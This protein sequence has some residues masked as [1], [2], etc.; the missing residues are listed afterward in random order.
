M[1][2]AKSNGR[3][4]STPQLTIL[5]P[6]RNEKDNLELL[7]PRLDFVLEGIGVSSETIVVDGDSTDG[8]LEMAKRHCALAFPQQGAGYG[9]ALKQGF[10]A[11][12]GEYIV[13]LDADLSHD[14]KFIQRLWENREGVDVVVASRYCEGG[15]A[16]APFFRRFLS[17]V[18]N[19]F[20]SAGFGVPVTDVSSGFRL[21][22]GDVVKAVEFASMRERVR[23]RLTVFTGCVDQYFGYR[24]GRLPYRSIRFEHEHLAG[25]ERFQPV[26]AA[27]V[28]YPNEHAYTRITEFKHITG[29][30]HPGTSI[31]REFPTD[32]GEPYY[33][34]PRP[35]NQ[36]LYRRYQELAASEPK[37]VFLGRLAQYRYYNMDQAAAAALKAAAEIV[38]G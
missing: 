22:K 7:F 29:Q 19:W 10:K 30:Q 8:T 33:P 9:L 31:V 35:A 16:Q 21:Y 24:L 26:P 11:A 25:V 15:A 13:T 20:F 34:V 1:D 18:L 14:P 4:G 5:L 23:P 36:E 38:G 37:A 12:S 27:T 17:N 32:E 3:N 6:T 2:T 28:N